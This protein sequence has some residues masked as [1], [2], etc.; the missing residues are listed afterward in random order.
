LNM[1]FLK[2]WGIS[3]IRLNSLQELCLFDQLRVAMKIEPLRKIAENF[4]I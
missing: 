4:T 2:A 1:P 3:I